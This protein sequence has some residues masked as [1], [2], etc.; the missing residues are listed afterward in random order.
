MKLL[1]YFVIQWEGFYCT[2]SLFNKVPSG[3]KNTI[4]TNI[5]VKIASTKCFAR[6]NLIKDATQYHLVKS[7][8]QGIHRAEDRKRRLKYYSTI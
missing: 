2:N 6:A 7:F 1:N 3:F 8:V 4:K 5:T